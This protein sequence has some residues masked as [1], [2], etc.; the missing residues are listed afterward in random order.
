MARARAAEH[1]T[2]IGV[3]GREWWRRF[4]IEIFRVRISRDEKFAFWSGEENYFGI[5]SYGDGRFRFRVRVYSIYTFRFSVRL[6]R[7]RRQHDVDS[8]V[9]FS[10]DDGRMVFRFGLSLV[11]VVKRP[12]D[13]WKTSWRNAILSRSRESTR[14]TY[15]PSTP[16][17]AATIY[18]TTIHWW[19]RTITRWTTRI[20]SDNCFIRSETKRSFNKNINGRRRVDD[21]RSRL[22][23]RRLVVLFE[24]FQIRAVPI[25]QRDFVNCSAN[26][27]YAWPF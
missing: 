6:K 20:D 19:T 24:G 27:S 10:N 4:T 3:G 25:V 1:W 8:F 15:A 17:I 5:S 18:V 7:A 22:P 2:V 9:R 14:T 21:R 26:Y 23:R 13:V 11:V 16:R 12:T